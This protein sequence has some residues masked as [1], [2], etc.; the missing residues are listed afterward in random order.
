M[1]QGTSLALML[2]PIGILAVYNYHVAGEIN[3]V[4]AAVI[5]LTF[6]VGGY[7]GSKLS[8]R[9]NPQTVKFIFGVVM[10]YISF[11]LLASSYKSFFNQF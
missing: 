9:I 3:W 7:F 10:L 2:P 6:V 5:A 4:Y 8:L 1:A 11:N